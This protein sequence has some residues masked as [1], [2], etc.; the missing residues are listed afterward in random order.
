MHNTFTS[1]LTQEIMDRLGASNRAFDKVYPGDTGDRQAVHTV[2]GG[3]HIFKADTAGKM[4]AAA[5]KQL[6]AYA[7]HF[8]DF[9]RILGLPGW[10]ELPR[11]PDDQ[12]TL[13]RELASGREPRKDGHEAGTLARTIYRR[14]V[15]KL[16]R[17]PVE[18][19]RID[20]EDGYG[21]RPDEEEDGHAASAAVEVAQGMSSGSLPPFIGIRIKPL[22]EEMKARAVRTLDIFLSTLAEE[23]GGRLPGNFVVTLPKVTTPEQVVALV[24]LFRV[25]E[26]RTAFAE[27]ALNLE[28]MVETPQSILN[29][30]G[31]SAL[32]LL[33]QAA[34]GRC[35]AAHFGVYDYTASCE[36]TAAYQSMTHPICD[37][38]RHLMKVAF[39][40]TGIRLSDGATNIMPVAPHRPAQ[41]QPLT[42][43]Q[44]RE[45][46]EA[47]HQAWKLG[48]DHIR[49]SLRNGFYQGWDLHPAQLP[50]RY[51]ALYAFFLEGL[52]SASL[53]LRTFIDQAAQ[54]TLVGNVFDDAATGQALLNYFLRGLSCGAVTEEE[55]AATGLSLEDIRTRSF[56]AILDRR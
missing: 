46:R 11:S 47:V 42:K 13:E 52:E 26:E 18:D 24:G 28:L 45:N 43:E 48:Y 30:N 6:D 23:T 35:V 14:V 53:R 4:G 20:F 41:G 22:S 3:A 51:A 55:V 37:V 2:Y 29:S 8:T 7:P 39:A 38:A 5:L 16:Q 15:E 40:G 32:P 25:L 21:N 44:E 33:N 9:A 50:I 56:K 27:G 10:E 49:H 31:E 54:A 34:D 1:D 36:I 19:F 12:A 17:E